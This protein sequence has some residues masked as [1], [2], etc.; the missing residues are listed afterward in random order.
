MQVNKIACW[1]YIANIR[2]TIRMVEV[3]INLFQTGFNDY[4][5]H[6]LSSIICLTHNLI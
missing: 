2:M 4:P 5:F 6:C 3:K 1:D